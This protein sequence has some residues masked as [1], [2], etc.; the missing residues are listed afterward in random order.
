MFRKMRRSPQAL[1]EEEIIEVLKKETRG[2]LSV[3]GDDGYPYGVPI[4][5]YYDEETG[6]LSTSMALIS[7][8]ELTRSEEILRF[9]TVCSDRISRRK[10]TGLNMSKA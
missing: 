9:H 7:A 4:N 2:V 1:T 5:H 10:A 3:Q 6:K 8:T